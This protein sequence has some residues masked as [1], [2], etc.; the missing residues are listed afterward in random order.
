MVQYFANLER[1]G[2]LLPTDQD[3]LIISLLEPERFLEF[4]QFFMLYDKKVGKI[5][6][7]YQQFF[8]IGVYCH[9]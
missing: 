3:R 2:D 5:A 7:R 8:G 6:A 4:V 9:L 1:S